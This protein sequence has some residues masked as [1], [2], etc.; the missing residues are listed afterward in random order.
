MSWRPPPQIRAIAIGVIRRGDE[1]LVYEGH[2]PSNGETFH[3]TLG[4]G[5]DFGET[6]VEALAREFREEIGCDLED[7][8][9]LGTL[10]NI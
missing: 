7:A 9:Y 2:D 8:R 6:G 5:I 4:G 10:E 3:R 1:I